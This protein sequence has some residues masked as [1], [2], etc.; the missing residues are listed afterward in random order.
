MMLHLR[1]HHAYPAVTVQRVIETCQ[2]CYISL[3]CKNDKGKQ[4][5]CSSAKV[6]TINVMIRLIKLMEHW[7]PAKCN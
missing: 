6:S 7:L 4:I 5:Y 1:Q 2:S 3:V